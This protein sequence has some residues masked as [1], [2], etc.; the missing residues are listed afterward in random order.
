[1]SPIIEAVGLLLALGGDGV[2]PETKVAVLLAVGDVGAAGREP[3]AELVCSL[4]GT[5]LRLTTM[6]LAGGDRGEAV[7]GLG[8]CPLIWSASPAVMSVR[9]VATGT[10]CDGG[11]TFR[12]VCGA[13]G[14][15]DMVV[16]E[17]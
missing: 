4:G 16:G 10:I 9:M 13:F 14:G 2:V 7:A 3:V 6:G 17:Q 15:A 11:R 1:M 8:A 5:G 12:L